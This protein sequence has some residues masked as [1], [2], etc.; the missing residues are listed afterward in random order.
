[1]RIFSDARGDGHSPRLVILSEYVDAAQNSTGYYWSKIIQ[2]LAAEFDQLCVICPQSSYR[3]V[4]GGDPRVAYFPFKDRTYDKN[5]L[6]SR[7]FGQFRQTL[8][9]AK[10]LIVHVRRGDAVFSG[11]NPS[12]SLLLVASIKRI[13]GFRWVLLVHDVFPENLLAAQVIRK[14]GPLYMILSV[15]FNRAYSSPDTVIA[16]GRDMLGLLM[17]KTGNRSRVIYIP[18]WVD[19][20]DV[21]PMARDSGNLFAASEWKDKVVFQFFGNFGRVQGLANLLSA[22]A[23]VRSTE[24]AFIFIGS[25]SE[26]KL[27]SRFI[28]QYPQ[29]N[30]IRVP[31]LSFADNN[32]GLSAC[33]VAI[34]SL[35]KGMKGLAVPSKAYFSLAADKPLLV[36]SDKDSELHRL[37]SEERMIG[38]FCECENPTAL[39]KSIDDICNLNLSEF[40]GKPRSVL[41]EKYGYIDAIKRY[42]QCIHE[43]LDSPT[44][45]RA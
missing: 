29:L 42:S 24:A 28:A 26:D 20:A 7:L 19:P 37:V 45:R 11:T 10:Q 13:I 9:F 4:V 23:H 22:L 41:I 3:R 15:L 40:R 18:N 8:R 2:G 27:V 17:D 6:A 36:V 35:D 44:R 30:I 5:K 33:D 12:L 21:T 43:V 16:I 31:Q 34:V 25:G 39:A 1:M 32:L 38:W 14:K